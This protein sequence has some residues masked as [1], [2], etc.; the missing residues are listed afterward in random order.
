MLVGRKNC[1]K[2][3]QFL[4]EPLIKKQSIS[5]WVS[6]FFCVSFI[7]YRSKYQERI[8]WSQIEE[9]VVL[10]TF[11]RWVRTSAN[12]YEVPWLNQDTKDVSGQSQNRNLESKWN[13]TTKPS[14]YWL[15]C[16][17]LCFP[18]QCFYIFQLLVFFVTSDGLYRLFFLSI[19]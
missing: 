11:L 2:I 9:L 5:P 13:N 19:L 7:Q 4:V 14:F 15:F 12:F 1:R 18:F 3:V 17:L 16:L 6:G 10:K 8:Q